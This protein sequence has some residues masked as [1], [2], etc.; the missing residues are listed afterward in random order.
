MD[1]GDAGSWSSDWLWAVPLI[2]IVVAI[3]MV[4]LMLIDRKVVTV[5]GRASGRHRF[6]PWF[7]VVM[8]ITVILATILH[9]LEGVVWALAYLMLG[10]MPD[11]KAAMLYSISSMTSYGHA[12]VYLEARWQMLGALEALNGMMMFGVTTAFLFST[13]QKLRM[14][15]PS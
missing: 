2:L 6:L 10:A 8:G 7:V 12:D 3:H 9:G 11:S 13:M 4:G 15:D 14:F 5:L 1:I